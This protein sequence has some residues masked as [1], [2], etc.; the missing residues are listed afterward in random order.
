MVSAWH[1][2]GPVAMFLHRIYVPL[3]NLSAESP[4]DATGRGIDTMDL[5]WLG[6]V[7]V[8]YAALLWLT[9]GCEAL[10]PRK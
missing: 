2:E 1:P 3:P 10:Q 5:I 6:V 4:I 8:C 7:L 9:R